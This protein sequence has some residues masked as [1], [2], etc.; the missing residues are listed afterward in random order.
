MVIAALRPL[1][2]PNDDPDPDRRRARVARRAARYDVMA[3][4]E[5]QL[6]PV[7]SS[8][9]LPL[10]SE[11]VRLP[12]VASFLPRYGLAQAN[13]G[14]KKAL[15]LLQKAVFRY[16]KLRSYEQLF[17]G[18]V[19]DFVKDFDS[20]V[21]FA[22]RRIAGPNPLSL[23]KVPD[24][25][26]LEALFFDPAAVLPR[27]ETQLGGST[28]DAE[29]AAGKLFFL[30]YRILQRSL[31]PA[32]TRDTRWRR[33]YLPAPV[34]VFWENPDPARG[35]DLVPLVIQVDQH[36]ADPP[37]R[38]WYPTDG[39]GWRIGK[40]YV[41]VA[42]ENF[43]VAVGHVLRTHLTMDPFCMATYRNLDRSHPV[44][45]LLEPHLRFTLG[46]NEAAYNNF[47]DRTDAYFTFYAGTLE[48]LRKTVTLSHGENDLWQL[49]LDEEVAARGVE[50]GPAE[51]PYRDDLSLYLAPIRDFVEGYLNL[52][53]G[54]DA[55]VFADWELQAWAAE[56]QAGD[57]GHVRGLFRPGEALDS[58]ATLA[59]ILAQVIFIAG[60][61]H[62]SQH[63]S[64]MQYYRY[65]PAF[66]ASAYAPPPADASGDTA[67][68]WRD[69]L[70]PFDA[71]NLR[72]AYSTFGDFRFDRFGDYRRYRLGWL[73]AARPLVATFQASLRD[74][75]TTME[76]RDRDRHRDCS[77]YRPS[78][79]PNSINI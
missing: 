69:M 74:I 36:D 16:D 52:F 67:A 42:D 76:A 43:H 22:W 68:H 3:A 45:V 34:A 63:F 46:T 29:I 40:L 17:L 54:S 20:D 4:S 70:P 7:M 14:A 48:E 21:D 71:A 9:K 47:V 28:V 53:Y 79:V 31:V 25:A 6:A 35:C 10:V 64:Q 19:P 77:F 56:L 60:P 38:V 62:A 12:W 26:R 75:E 57:R 1:R 73:R 5:N 41:E 65:P 30:D 32:A 72:F 78:R 13:R 24:R 2:L 49:A 59:R 27:I 58:I 23:T 50:T 18:P 61:G 66:A 15:S 33:K 44:H 11:K 51:Y 39:V 55:D 37:N 8:G